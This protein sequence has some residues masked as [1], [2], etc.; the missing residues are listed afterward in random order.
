MSNEALLGLA[1]RLPLNPAQLREVTE[2]PPSIA[3]RYGPA[4][5]QRITEAL[6]TPEDSWPRLV[7]HRGPRPDA[8]VD[9]RLERLKQMRNERARELGIEPGVLCPNGTLEALARLNVRD[10]QQM[11]AIPE[12]RKWQREALGL[13]SIRAALQDPAPA[14]G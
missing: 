8:D 5:L 9:A 1:K 10:A 4:L 13:D 6:A 11:E 2:L 3:A 14:A 12:L 7:R